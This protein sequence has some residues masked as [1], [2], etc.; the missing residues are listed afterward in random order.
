MPQWK[1]KMVIDK[2][3]AKAVK[4]FLLNYAEIH[5]LSSP[6]RSINRIIQSVIF[7]PTEWVINQFLEI[8]L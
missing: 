2:N 3:I 1:T 7:L 6:E 5:E 4:N 8:F